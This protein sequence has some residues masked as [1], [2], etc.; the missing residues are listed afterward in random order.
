M[1]T[2]V[3]NKRSLE[4]RIVSPANFAWVVK[5]EDESSPSDQYVNISTKSLVSSTVLRFSLK[6][7]VGEI[8]FQGAGGSN[9]IIYKYSGSSG[10]MTAMTITAWLNQS[11]GWKWKGTGEIR[12]LE[13]R[14]DHIYVHLNSHVYNN[15]D[16]TVNGTYYFTIGGF[17]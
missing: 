2:D 6:S 13:L 8:L 3:V 7:K 17:F 4:R 5:T 9:Q 1:V 11:L 15:G 16:F 14:N 10:A 12:A